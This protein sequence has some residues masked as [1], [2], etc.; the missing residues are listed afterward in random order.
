MT[1]PDFQTL[2]HDPAHAGV[3]H[4]PAA[5]TEAI[6]A[7]A[8]ANGFF[9]F[10]INLG[11]VRNKDELLSRIG[12]TMD[13]PEW[14]GYNFDALADC[15]TDLGWRPAEGYLVLMENCDAICEKNES[16]FAAT[17]R[18]FAMAA[19]TWREQGI[20]FWCLV[21]MQTD[22]TAWLPMLS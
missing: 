8:E 20:A 1:F 18:I 9:I 19:A 17:L 2:L 21:E 13:F 22:G 16:D 4:P 5:S 10:R 14:F 15:L 11:T 7:G 6:I 3:Y 12:K